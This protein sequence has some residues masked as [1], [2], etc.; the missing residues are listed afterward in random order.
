MRKIASLYLQVLTIPIAVSPRCK[1][2]KTADG[3]SGVNNLKGRLFAPLHVMR[4][5]G[6]ML[7]DISSW[8]SSL[9]AYGR[10]IWEI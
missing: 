6:A 7:I 2:K 8:K 4:I 1:K 3:I 5:L 10:R 9:Q